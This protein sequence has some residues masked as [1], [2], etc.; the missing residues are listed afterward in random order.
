M[1]F[2]S[3]SVQDRIMDTRASISFFPFTTSTSR[4]PPGTA[5]SHLPPKHSNLANAT[6]TRWSQHWLSNTYPS[7]WSKSKSRRD[8][9]PP[10]A[11]TVSVDEGLL[12]QVVELEM[13][14][15]ERGKWTGRRDESYTESKREKKRRMRQIL[16]VGALFG[17]GTLL[18]GLVVICVSAGGMMRSAA[19]M[20]DGRCERAEELMNIGIFNCSLHLSR[21][22]A[23]WESDAWSS[24]VVATRPNSE[25]KTQS[26]NSTQLK[27]LCNAIGGRKNQKASPNRD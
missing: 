13:E 26:L 12:S 14:E 21:A 22:E 19:A 10:K 1:P 9:D 20:E 25:A 3:S 8:L 17:V 18:V 24:S 11:R 4:L 6:K 15:Q 23:Q 7:V 2:H 27:A 16:E 5:P